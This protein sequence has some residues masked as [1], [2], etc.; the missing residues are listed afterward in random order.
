ML[1]QALDAARAAAL[2][3]LKRT[4]D[5]EHGGFG[6]APKFPHAA[7]LDFCLRAF[8]RTGDAGTTATFHFCPTC[9][10]IVYYDMDAL[11]DMIAIPVGAFADSTFPGPTISVYETRQ[12][13]WLSLS[14]I[15][16]HYD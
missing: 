3:G 13:P 7:E 10:S 9:A 15:T 5:R 4:F 6:A 14:G 11:P 2:D 1:H 16:E 8:A 12:H